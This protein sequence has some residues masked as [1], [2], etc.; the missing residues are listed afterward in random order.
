MFW[1]PRFSE[2]ITTIGNTVYVPDSWPESLELDNLTFTAHEAVH[3]KDANK[4]PLFPLLYLFP[5][6]FWPLLAIGLAFISPW[7]LFVALLGA[8]PMPAPFR[9][10]SELR[11]YRM[12][13]LIIE[14]ILGFQKTSIEY[15]ESKMFFVTQMVGQ[16]YFWAMPLKGYVIKKFDETGWETEDIYKDTIEFCNVNIPRYTSSV[17]I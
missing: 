14:K 6:I 5:Q 1:N 17:G 8:L 16:W 12:N 2:Y 11:A 13:L 10:F 7:F 9:F 15:Q 3:A 4:N